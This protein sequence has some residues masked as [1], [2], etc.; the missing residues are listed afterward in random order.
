M[1]KTS[2]MKQFTSDEEEALRAFLFTNPYGRT[3]FVYPQSLIAG[4]ELSPLMSAYSRTHL[5]FQTR[6]LQFLDREKENQTRAMLP[7]INPLMDIFREADGTLKVSRRTRDFNTEFVLLH[8]HASIKEETN[9]FGY[10]EDVSDIALKKISGHPLNRP[11]VKSTRYLSYGKVLELGLQDEDILSLPNAAEATAH[12]RFLNQRYLEMSAQLGEAVFY[13]PFTEKALAYLRQPTQIEKEIESWM[14]KSRRENPNFNPGDTDL[15]KKRA[16]ILAGL[17][18]EQAQ[19]DIGKFVLDVSRVYLPAVTRT[20]LGF[21]ADARTLEEIIVD[22]LSSPRKEDQ[23]RGYE[24]W[25]EAKKIAPVLLGEQSHI[26][27]D[28]WR[29]HNEQAFRHYVQEKFATVEP[30]NHGSPT[31]NLLTPR[32]IEMYTDRF[33]AALAVFPYVDLALQDIMLNITEA[34]VKEILAKAHAARGDHDVLHPAISHGGLSV[35]MVMGYHGYRD[36][37][38]QRRGSRSTQLLT[39]RLGFEIPP[40][41]TAFGFSDIY[42]HDMAHAAAIY[43][44]ARKTSPHTAEKLVPFGAHCRALHSWQQNQIGYVGKLRSDIATGNFSY[45]ATTRELMRAFAQEMPET[46]KYMRWGQKE[47]PPILWK[48]GYGWFDATQRGEQ[49]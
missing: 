35:E 19:K 14:R 39:T 46:A 26:K 9:L 11:Q 15:E 33:N 2:V 37:F 5:P 6:V 41:L 30:R 40:M 22:M 48:K 38:R 49:Q 3:S 23:T 43:E 25:N 42:K 8:G 1:Q 45:V 17:E 18:P 28:N 47:Y 10:A 13:H 31:V 4:E 7:M 32:T 12:I 24:L 36:L 16:D 44:E 21:S 29:V 34:D 20:S 27:I